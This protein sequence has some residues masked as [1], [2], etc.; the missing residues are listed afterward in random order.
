M[1]FH[2][3]LY[4]YYDRNL[5]HPNMGYEYYGIGN[6]LELEEVFPPSDLEMMEEIVPRFVDEDHFMVY[7]L[8]VSGHLNYNREGNVMSDR[9]YDEVAGLPY[10]EG[11][12]CYLA[13]QQELELAMQDGVDFL[14]LA[15]PIK[16]ENGVL[17]CEKMRLGEPD[18][19]GRRSPVPTGRDGRAAVRPR[20]L[21]RRRAGRGAG[22]YGQRHHAQCEG[23]SCLLH[24]RSR[25]LCCR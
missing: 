17:T 15:A 3:Y 2:D 24:E 1:A 13:C 25:R 7:C 12:K 11:V 19:S 8:T 16:Q 14:E 10:S 6:G 4:T 18:A 5:S 23:P 21:R 9:H 22:V 20:N